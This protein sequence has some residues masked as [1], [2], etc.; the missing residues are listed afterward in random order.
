MDDGGGEQVEPGNAVV[1]ALARTVAN[2]AVA[3]NPEHEAQ[4]IVPPSSHPDML[5]DVVG[6][7]AMA[8]QGGLVR[9]KVEQDRALARSRCFVSACSA[10]PLSVHPDLRCTVRKGTVY[11]TL[12]RHHSP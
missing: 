5:D 4:P 3:L 10:F 8:Q 9:G 1:L 6:Q 2:F 7:R 11:R 12:N